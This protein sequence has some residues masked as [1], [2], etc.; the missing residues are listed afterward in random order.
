[1]ITSDIHNIIEVSGLEKTF[2]VKSQNVSVL[3]EI[4][5]KVGHGEFL[6]I[7]GPSGCG[8]STL[9]HTVLGLEEPTKGVVKFMGTSLYEGMNEDTRSDFRKK[10]VG[11]VYQQ[12]NWIKAL[13][14]KENVMFALRLN[15]VSERDASIRAGAV[16]EMV[17]MTAWQDYLPTELSSG[18]QQKVA[19]ARA[20]VTDP[21]ILIT[22]EPTG[23]LDFQSGQEL[24]EL[25]SLLNKEGKTVIM[26][27]H[28]LEYLSYATRA[29][30]MFDGRIVKETIS[31]SNSLQNDAAK[32]K[33]KRGEHEEQPTT[34][35]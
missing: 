18:Q 7:F 29:L 4:N 23:N 16:L 35:I 3:T 30:E 26:V 2:F 21:D 12:P 20:I 27:T 33:F 25:L 31:P 8:K 10:H 34:R 15:G 13:T 22:D 19:L 14:V 11:M 17:L 1:M 6:V 5:F 32:I 9:L 24:M 28:D